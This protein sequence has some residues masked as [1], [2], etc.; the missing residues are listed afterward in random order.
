MITIR[1]A[2]VSD[3][4]MICTAEQETAQTPGLL[5]SRPHELKPSSF[6]QT[7]AQ[8]LTGR[9]RYIVAEENGTLVGHAVL[10][11]L[12]LEALA[13]VFTLT[14]VVH[15]NHLGKHIGTLLM[16]NLADW[17]AKEPSCQKIELRVR[18]TNSVAR[19]LY[20]KFRIVEESVFK[21]RVRLPSGAVVDDVTMAWFPSCKEG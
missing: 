17:A 6:E 1:E 20:A 7:I 9:G 16:Q 21:K 8:C 3:A 4:P 13:H 12:D 11:P 19:S 10:G 18:A 2:Q 5:V 15:P 14:I